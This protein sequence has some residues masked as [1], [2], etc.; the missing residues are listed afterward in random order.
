MPVSLQSEQQTIEN[1]LNALLA[2]IDA[3]KTALQGKGLVSLA[4]L[5]IGSLKKGPA[6]AFISYNIAGVS[7]TKAAVT[8]G[9]ALSGATLPAS[10]KCGAWALDIDVAGTISIAEAPSNAPGYTTVALAIVGIPAVA[11]TKARLG[12]VTVAN[13]SAGNFV[14]GTTDLDVAGLT[15]AY[16]DATSLYNS[17]PV[18][19]ATA[20]S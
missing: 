4:G 6:T 3:I 10:G 14:P 18:S 20:G 13:S 17:L 9:T 19:T 2:D 7:Y 12:T 16:A 11:T 8:T 1:Q 5:A 15:V